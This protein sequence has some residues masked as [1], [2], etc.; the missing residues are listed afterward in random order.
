[1]D[2]V[3]K[4]HDSECYTPSSEPIRIYKSIVARKTTGGYWK[5]NNDDGFHKTNI[6]L[7]DP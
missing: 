1:M 6:S 4:F 3:Q 5:P 7:L 2:K